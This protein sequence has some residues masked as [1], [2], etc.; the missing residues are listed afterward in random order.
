DKYRLHRIIRGDLEIGQIVAGDIDA[1]RMDYL[2]RDAH[3]TGVK[4]G[5]IDV[6][7]IIRLA[8]I[9]SRRL[10]YDEKAV[11]SLE[12]LLASRF[13]M[14]KSVYKHH[15]VE[16]AEKMVQRA[17]DNHLEDNRLERIM[18][19]DDYD[20]HN[21]LL[22]S[23][24]VSCKMYERVKNRKL[25]KRAFIYR[26]DQGELKHL[27]QRMESPEEI[28][29]EIAER[30]G[31]ESHEVIVDPPSTPG[32]TDFDIKIKKSNGEV[33]KMSEISHFPDMLSEAEWQTVDLK[34]YS[35]EEVREEVREAASEKV[36]N[37]IK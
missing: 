25:Y 13:H 7:T 31:V 27:E 34:V 19:L 20:A 22:E 18:R 6:D 16:I 2:I 12:S 28:E 32:I 8:E 36:N 3:A 4:H 9:D 17:L 10:V 11:T 37:M 24:G 23:E 15:A 33:V 30:A 5:E 35:P 21:E 1:D 26:G 29:R 14:T